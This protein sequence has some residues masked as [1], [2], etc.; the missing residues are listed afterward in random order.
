VPEKLVTRRSPLGYLAW[1]ATALM[2]AVTLAHAVRRGTGW[3]AAAGGA[4]LFVLYGFLP[5][6]GAAS[7][8]RRKKSLAAVTVDDRGVTRTD[9]ELRESVAWDDLAW[10]RIF[11]NSAG[12]GADD[13]FFAL[14]AGNGKGCLVPLELATSS[15][16]L[17][18]L[19]QRLPGLDNAAVALAMGSTTEAVFT[20]WKRPDAATTAPI[21][22]GAPS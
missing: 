15:H 4:L 6:I 21:T 19:Q 10:V 14:G 16:L 12:P 1:G 5:R 13:V 18:A 11:T 20:I 7:A 22:P 17:E 9:G 3:G 2:A 8:R